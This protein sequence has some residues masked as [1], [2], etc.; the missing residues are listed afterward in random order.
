M[1]HESMDAMGLR[2]DLVAVFGE[3]KLVRRDGVLRL[4]GGTMADRMEA[5]E[6]VMMFLPD[7]AV[8]M[9]R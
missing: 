7:E 9:R 3:A 1:N 2:D 4:M 5:M 8:R 6:W